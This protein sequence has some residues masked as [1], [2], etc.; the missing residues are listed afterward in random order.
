M[1]SEEH[2]AVKAELIEDGPDKEAQEVEELPDFGG[3]EE[4]I[5]SSKNEAPV[6][7]EEVEEKL[8]GEPRLDALHLTGTVRHARCRAQAMASHSPTHLPRCEI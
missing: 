2:E 8:K 1:I 7:K 3:E 5:E 6:K 4:Q